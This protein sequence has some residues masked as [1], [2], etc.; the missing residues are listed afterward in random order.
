MT[1]LV[2]TTGNELTRSI[3]AEIRAPGYVNSAKLKFVPVSP[4]P[5]VMPT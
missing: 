1:S 5:K 3:A 4:S 2:W